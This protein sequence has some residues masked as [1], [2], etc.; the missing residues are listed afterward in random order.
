MIRNVSKTGLLLTLSLFLLSLTLPDRI[1]ELTVNRKKL[2]KYAL[3]YKGKPYKYGGQSPKGFDCSGFTGYV[4]SEFGVKLPRR[5]RDQ[6]KFGKKVK[7]KKAQPG[8]LIS[9]SNKGKV[10]HVGIV[11]AQKNGKLLVVHASSK[12]GIVVEDINA[13]SYWKSRI[14]Q[15]RNVL[16]KD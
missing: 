1:N 6:A 3:K 10:H 5:S 9:F 4:Y 16:P 12:R 14:H 8:D 2:V 11:A 15:I 13:S 7:L